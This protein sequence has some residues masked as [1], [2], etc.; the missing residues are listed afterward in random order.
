MDKHVFI[1]VNKEEERSDVGLL[2]DE[3]TFRRYFSGVMN[4]RKIFSKMS[5]GNYITL[6]IIEQLIR[7]EKE[8]QDQDDKEARIY[9]KD[10]ES[11]FKIP[12]YKISDLVR[13]LS[14]RGLVTWTHDGKGEGGTYITITESGLKAA[15]EQQA[16]LK[17]FYSNVIERYGKDKF[18]NLLGM[19]GE[20]DQVMEAELERV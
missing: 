12:M 10:M 15:Q 20:L 3:M 6:E 19:M 2:S 16:I 17:E 18:V 7:K 9:L 4:T 1:D 13:D 11:H 14:E 8:F 5:T